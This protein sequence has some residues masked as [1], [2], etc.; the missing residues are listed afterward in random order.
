MSIIC[1]HCNKQLSSKYYLQ[2]HE[3]ICTQTKVPITDVC[4]YCSKTFTQSLKNHEKICPER[5]FECKHCSKLLGSKQSLQNHEKKCKK[6]EESEVGKPTEKAPLHSACGA[7]S[8]LVEKVVEKVVIETVYEED[9]SDDET[10]VDFKTSVVPPRR[11]YDKNNIEKIDI[12]KEREAIEEDTEAVFKDVEERVTIKVER[13]L[14]DVREEIK[15]VVKPEEQKNY[16]HEYEKAL[17][18]TYFEIEINEIRK[19]NFEYYIM[20]K[21]M[22]DLVMRTNN[23]LCDVNIKKYSPDKTPNT[24]DTIFR[25]IIIDNSETL[26]ETN[27]QMMDLLYKNTELN[28]SFRTRFHENNW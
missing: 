22:M 4:Q 9:T 19:I 6:V 7:V 2:T 13:I 1:R 24:S 11:V 27:G 3:K 20:N 28:K 26:L 25:M 12:E 16:L 8:P 14:K 21:E 18:K 15:D 10:S 23:E 17:L 5:K